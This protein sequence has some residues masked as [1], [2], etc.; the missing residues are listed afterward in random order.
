MALSFSC[1][2]SLCATTPPHI[3]PLYLLPH[4]QCPCCHAVSQI[5]VEILTS[6]R[7]QGGIDHQG[8]E[9]KTDRGV[10]LSSTLQQVIH[11]RL[12]SKYPPKLNLKRPPSVVSFR[13][14]R[15][16]ILSSLLHTYKHTFTKAN[17]QRGNISYA[18]LQH[19]TLS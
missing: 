13:W 11:L 3:S 7:S 6:D 14:G 1:P 8:G 10:S 19:Y 12:P 17:E 4:R 2:C 15:L 5:N 16:V 9:G 18:C